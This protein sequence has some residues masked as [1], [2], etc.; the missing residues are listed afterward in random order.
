MNFFNIST[1]SR[2]R[3]FLKGFMHA[4]GSLT[5]QVHVSLWGSLAPLLLSPSSPQT[6]TKCA[7]SAF[8]ESCWEC[9]QHY[10]DW[11]TAKESLTGG[12]GWKRIQGDHRVTS[13]F[14]STV[15]CAGDF[16]NSYCWVINP[17]PSHASALVF[18]CIFLFLLAWL[19]KGS[20][21][22]R[23]GD[24]LPHEITGA[25]GCKCSTEEREVRNA[26]MSVRVQAPWPY[27]IHCY[28]NTVDS[29]QCWHWPF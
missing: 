28:W 20:V 8:Q 17:I 9:W 21:D 11:N 25:Q 6:R 29:S 2:I 7:F 23:N 13:T 26:E 15:N 10:R 22:L 3:F 5:G 16:V 24:C 18:A 27:S 12:P 4:F 14:R 1:C 19:V